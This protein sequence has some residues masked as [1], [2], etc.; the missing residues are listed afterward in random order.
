[1]II[2]NPRKGDFFMFAAVIENGS[3]WLLDIRDNLDIDLATLEKEW[4]KSLHEKYPVK[5][6]KKVLNK[7]KKQ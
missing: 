5:I 3:T 1:M 6:N 2:L 7:I 4:V